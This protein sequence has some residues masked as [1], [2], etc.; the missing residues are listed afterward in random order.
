MS[1]TLD[2]KPNCLFRVGFC[3]YRPRLGFTSAASAMDGAPEGFCLATQWLLNGKE[4]VGCFWGLGS[5][6]GLAMVWCLGCFWGLGFEVLF[7]FRRLYSVG[8][9]SE[10]GLGWAWIWV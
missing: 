10:L 3:A 2:P 9:W 8:L 6:W 4:G 5:I 7:G 1:K